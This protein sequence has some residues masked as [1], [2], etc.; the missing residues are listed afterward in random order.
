MM[1][2]ETMDKFWEAVAAYIH[3][4][5]P[6]QLRVYQDGMVAD[7]EIGRR[8]VKEAVVRGSKNYRLVQELLERA[9]ELRKTE[10]PI[11][12]LQEHENLLRQMGQEPAAEVEG[13]TEQY[14]LQG[15]RLMEERDRCKTSAK[16]GH[17]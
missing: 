13:D 15:D 1:H 8:I 2:K 10:D 4:F 17:I 5:D 12:L 14:R 3:S 9:A 7:G 11:L 6:H 16:V